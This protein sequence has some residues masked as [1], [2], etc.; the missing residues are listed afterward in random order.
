VPLYLT[1]SSIWIGA[2]RWPGSYLPQLLAERIAADQIATCVPVALEVLVGPPDGRA[3]K[4]DWD[5]VWQKLTWLPVGEA[6]SE[7]ALELLQELAQTT[8][9]AHR[10]RPIDYLVAA[11]AEARAGAVLWHWDKDLTH[12]CDHAGIPQEPEHDRAK[13]HKINTEPGRTGR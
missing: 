1:D 2:R 5:A 6:V 9:G 8:A 13:R 7:R 4:Q 3:L 10:R 11:C 12:I